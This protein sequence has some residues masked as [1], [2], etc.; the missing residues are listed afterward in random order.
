[1]Q[2]NL[3]VGTMIATSQPAAVSYLYY[4][5]RIYQLPLA[6]IG[7]AVGV[8][9]LPELARALRS[10]GEAAA[11]ETQNRCIE[12]ALLLTL[13]ATL[14]LIAIP[15]PIVTVLY[16]R[17][18]FDAT[19]SYATS[20]A[21]I[22]YTLGLPAYVLAKA[23]TPGF[24]A[25]EDTATPFRFAMISL[26]FNVALSLSLFQFLNYAGIALATALA[27]WLNVSL[28]SWRLHRRGHF[29]IDAQLKRNM[30]RALV[31]SLIMAA[32]RQ[33]RRL[34]RGCGQLVVKVAALS[35]LVASGLGLFSPWR[36]RAAPSPR[37]PKRMLGA[38]EVG[39]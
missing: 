25:R 7:S 11:I 2:I 9:L 22:A 5:D 31:C 14:A 35:V 20:W 4:A 19:A 21:L 17:G 33:R 24:Y 23:L 6:V 38:P 29:R 30:P 10:R 12:Y 26:A 15:D 18:A 3:L 28:L 16:Q 32:A 8:V 34:W 27:S 1:M 39:P 13:P 36:W 37:E